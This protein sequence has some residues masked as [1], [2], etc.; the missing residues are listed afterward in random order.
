MNFG[1]QLFYLFLSPL[2]SVVGGIGY[3]HGRPPPVIF[4]GFYI[5][6]NT[7]PIALSNLVETTPYSFDQLSFSTVPKLANLSLSKNSMVALFCVILPFRLIGIH[8]TVG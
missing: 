8:M 3:I 5:N 4:C 6:S 1:C 2:C 7:T